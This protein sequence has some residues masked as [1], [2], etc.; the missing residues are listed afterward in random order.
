MEAPLE[1]TGKRDEPTFAI[2]G[3]DTDENEDSE[4]CSL[5]VYRFPRLLVEQYSF[6]VEVNR[7]P[8]V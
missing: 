3:V 4:I 2:A 5:S 8:F 7:I 1:T 6:L